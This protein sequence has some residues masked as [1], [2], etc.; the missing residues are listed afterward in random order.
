LWIRVFAAAPSLPRR[1]QVRV[2]ETDQHHLLKRIALRKFAEQLDDC[3]HGAR[4]LHFDLQHQPSNKSI[5]EFVNRLLNDVL[6]EKDKKLAAEK[7]A[8][9]KGCSSRTC[10][11]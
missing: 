10:C 5:K 9:A 7:K 4:L 3:R 2:I 11:G 6:K 8:A 1:N